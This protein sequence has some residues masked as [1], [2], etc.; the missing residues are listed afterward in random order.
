MFAHQNST[1]GTLQFM[2]MVALGK[3]TRI[4]PGALAHLTAM[5]QFIQFENH[6][7]AITPGMMAG[8]TSLAA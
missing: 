6:M 8:L 1:S 4:V 2:H 7:R 3:M 5:L